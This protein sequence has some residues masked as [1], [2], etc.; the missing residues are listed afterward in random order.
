MINNM[1]LKQEI[2]LSIC[3]S[4]ALLDNERSC[5]RENTK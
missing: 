1:Y 4:S 3:F 5:L 2:A